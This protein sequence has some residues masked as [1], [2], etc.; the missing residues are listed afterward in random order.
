MSPPFCVK[1]G[2][3]SSFILNQDSG[4]WNCPLSRTILYYSTIIHC[5]C[6]WKQISIVYMYIFPKYVETSIFKYNPKQ[7]TVFF[8][9]TQPLGDKS[10]L[11][12]VPIM[13]DWEVRPANVQC[14]KGKSTTPQNIP[15]WTRSQPL[16]SISTRVTLCHFMHKVTDR[17]TGAGYR[18]FA[19]F[20]ESPWKAIK[21]K[22]SNYQI[23]NKSVHMQLDTQHPLFIYKKCVFV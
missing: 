21:C 7:P 16:K 15:E 9:P 18:Q 5:M 22:C 2:N 17:H 12:T 10:A 19:E 4:S 3:L 20:I 8:I 13:S 6:I 11:H 1:E 23:C 14:N